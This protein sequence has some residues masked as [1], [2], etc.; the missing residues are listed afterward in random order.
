MFRLK[1]GGWQ[2]SGKPLPVDNQ[3]AFIGV[4]NRKFK[5]AFF[6][7]GLLGF[8]P[9]K[10]LSRFLERNFYVTLFTADADNLAGNNISDVYLFNDVPGVYKFFAVDN[11]GTERRQVNI[12]RAFINTYYRA[13]NE[14]INRGGSGDFIHVTVHY[15]R[16]NSVFFC[17]FA[18]VFNWN[19]DFFFN[20]RSFFSCAE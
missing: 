7:D 11:A 12:D 1:L 16:W 10:C 15:Q 14:I 18:D 19:F 6:A 17:F 2:K 8:V 20:Y 3:P 4:R 5:D 9:D 13:F